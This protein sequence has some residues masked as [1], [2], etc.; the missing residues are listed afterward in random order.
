MAKPFGNLAVCFT[1]R[2]FVMISLL[3]L[4]VFSFVVNTVRVALSRWDCCVASKISSLSQHVAQRWRCH[5]C[6]KLY[7]TVHCKLY[8]ETC[9][10]PEMRK[11]HIPAWS[12]TCTANLS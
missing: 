9:P 6:P 2:V 4:S 11:R 3:L 5:S 1:H 8:G 7:I 12:V 10:S